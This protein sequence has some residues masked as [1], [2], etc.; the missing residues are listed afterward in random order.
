MKC[1]YTCFTQKEKK[2]DPI[3]ITNNGVTM[4]EN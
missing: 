2:N 4:K 1:E 3:I